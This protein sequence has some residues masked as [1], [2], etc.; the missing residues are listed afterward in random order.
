MAAQVGH[1]SPDETQRR[2]VV[3]GLVAQDIAEWVEGAWADD[4]QAAQEASD[5]L[6]FVLDLLMRADT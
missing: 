3:Y 6:P 5:H 1:Y 2:P 4:S